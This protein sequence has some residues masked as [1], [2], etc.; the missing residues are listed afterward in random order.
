MPQNAA[1]S[2]SQD[3][4]VSGERTQFDHIN[5]PGAYICEWS[6]HLLRVPEDGVTQGRSPMI[7]MSANS[8]LYVRKISSNPY[9][10]ATKAR[11][12]A[13]DQDLDVNF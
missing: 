10:L 1:P 3:K 6:G 2:K 13:S 4:N 9:I 5:S 11:L 7:S 8:D 12:I